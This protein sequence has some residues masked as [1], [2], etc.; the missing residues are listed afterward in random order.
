M[1]QPPG[2]RRGL[3]PGLKGDR[4]GRCFTLTGGGAG[5]QGIGILT[6]EPEG[7]VGVGV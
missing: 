5:G 4:R 7:G 6:P 3:W 2:W 1:S